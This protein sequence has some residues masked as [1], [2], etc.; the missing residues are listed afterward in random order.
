MQERI[1]RKAAAAQ[2]ASVAEQRGMDNLMH[3]MGLSGIEKTEWENNM[4]PGQLHYPTRVGMDNHPLGMYRHGGGSSA[5]DGAIGGSLEGEEVVSMAAS[6][7]FSAVVTSKGE[8]WTFGACFNGCLGGNRDWSTAARRV[9][10]PLARALAEN[11]GAVRL[12]AGGTFCAA[13]TANGKV[14]VWGKVPKPQ[15]ACRSFPLPYPSM[16]I[17]LVCQ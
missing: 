1:K 2:Q 6:S 10:G 12:V 7:Y 14:V 17:F 13:L 16:N 5:L 11:G 9:G 8:V 4:Q 15:Q 3:A